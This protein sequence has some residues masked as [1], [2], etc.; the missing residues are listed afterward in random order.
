MNQLSGGQEEWSCVQYALAY[1]NVA[2]NLPRRTEGE[3]VLL[4]L[5]A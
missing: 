4:D 5:Q 2:D 1:L 3:A